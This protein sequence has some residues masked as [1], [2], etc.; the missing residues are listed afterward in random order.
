MFPSLGTLSV[1][2]VISST[3]RRQELKKGKKS[4]QKLSY[5]TP[6]RNE[7]SIESFIAKKGEKPQNTSGSASCTAISASSMTESSP[8]IVPAK[9]GFAGVSVADSAPSPA[10]NPSH[11]DPFQGRQ[12]APVA[13]ED[14]GGSPV[15]KGGDTLLPGTA[16]PAKMSHIETGR[17]SLS[18]VE[19]DINMNKTILR[20]HTPDIFDEDMPG[21]QDLNEGFSIGENFSEEEQDKEET[22]TCSLSSGPDCQPG[23]QEEQLDLFLR[24]AT[25][26]SLNVSDSEESSGA[27]ESENPSSPDPEPTV[28][29]EHDDFVD[30]MEDDT[31]DRE[32][33]SSDKPETGGTRPYA[34]SGSTETDNACAVD[35]DLQLLKLDK[36]AMSSHGISSGTLACA[37]ADDPGKRS[38]SYRS[39]RRDARLKRRL[40][41][42]R[43]QQRERVRQ[44]EEVALDLDITLPEG[45]LKLSSGSL[46][47][48]ETPLD[49]PVADPISSNPSPVGPSN[50]ES[51]NEHSRTAKVGR[52]SQNKG[53]GS[54]QKSP[55]S[56]VSQTNPMYGSLSYSDSDT[57]SLSEKPS[58]SHMFTLSRIDKIKRGSRKKRRLKPLS[59]LDSGSAS[60]TLE[61]KSAECL[62]KEGMYLVPLITDCM[63]TSPRRHQNAKHAENNVSQKSTDLGHS[64]V[65]LPRSTTT[66]SSSE[67]RSKITESLVS[68]NH[69]RRKVNKL[70]R[71]KRTTGTSQDNTMVTSPP[72]DNRKSISVERIQSRHLTPE[73]ETPCVEVEEIFADCFIQ[74]ELSQ[75]PVIVKLEDEVI[76]AMKLEIQ[77]VG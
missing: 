39:R 75:W 18:Y 20:P 6:G 66:D 67:S 38:R 23:P 34:Q 53:R 16:V 51:R 42:K 2:S 28:L 30:L 57:D 71:T 73:V 68:N 37:S 46:A 33:V 44:M 14:T 27:E 70:S 4:K 17:S 19:T 35:D 65:E 21:G 49:S 55:A 5:E 7:E 48:Q 50:R 26:P 10:L 61:R 64:P 45:A 31:C 47:S 36:P 32:Q 22:G 9:S 11:S 59:E 56:L 12:G 41:T 25:P 1:H 52:L 24:G 13:L 54:S 40:H 29:G 72:S 60:E 69:P 63:Q 58:L 8:G 15:P 62:S 77:R 76:S 74:E 3:K 43:I